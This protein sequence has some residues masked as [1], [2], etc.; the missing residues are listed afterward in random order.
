MISSAIFWVY[1]IE[2]NNT[3]A[4]IKCKSLEEAE[5]VR[6]NLLDDGFHAWIG[7]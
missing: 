1:Y 6:K 3:L 2:D 4:K 7:K 5:K